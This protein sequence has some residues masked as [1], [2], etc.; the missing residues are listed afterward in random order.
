MEANEILNK[1]EIKRVLEVIKMQ[2]DCD[3]SMFEDFVFLLNAKDKYHII[4]KNV[5]EFPVNKLRVNKYG[6]YFGELHNS[7]FRLSIEGSQLIGKSAKKN[8]ITLSDEQIQEWIRGREIEFDF[9]GTG[10]SGFVLIKNGK[11]FYGCGKY[12]THDKRLINYFP[13]VRRIG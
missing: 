4:N 12:L 7:E 11:D 10:A 2:W 9:T 3:V 6:M 8:I 1:K 13:K 5:F